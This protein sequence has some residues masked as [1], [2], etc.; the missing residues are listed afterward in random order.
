MANWPMAYAILTGFNLDKSKCQKRS[1][2]MDLAV[3]VKFSSSSSSINPQRS[4]RVH[5]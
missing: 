3:Y 5:K 4:Y 1:H 2:A